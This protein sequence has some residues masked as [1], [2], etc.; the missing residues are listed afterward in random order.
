MHESGDNLNESDSAYFCKRMRGLIL[1]GCHGCG[2]AADPFFC[3]GKREFGG[4]A[5]DC[6]GEVGFCVRLWIVSERLGFARGCGLWG[7]KL[8]C[9]RLACV[10][11]VGF[12]ARL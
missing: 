4:A 2:G 10:G 12:G 6:G 11:E 1:S 9:A 8:F 7:R 5:V 3:V